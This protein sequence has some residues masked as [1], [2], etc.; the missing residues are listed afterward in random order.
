MKKLLT[1]I[2]ILAMVISLAACA[3]DDPT[4]PQ[5]HPS[6]PSQTVPSTDSTDPADPTL[7]IPAPSNPSTGT[8]LIWLVQQEI[9]VY[10]DSDLG[11][12][13][14]DYTYDELGNCLTVR[15]EMGNYTTQMT[16]KYDE[17]GFN[18]C[19]I[20]TQSGIVM[21]YDYTPDEL[22]RR[23]KAELYINDILDNTQTFTYDDN[24][25]LLVLEQVSGDTVSRN[26]YRYD[27]N[28]NVLDYTH[29]VDEIVS[30]TVTLAY[31]EL[32]RQISAT[33]TN[34]Q[35][36]VVSIASYVYDTLTETQITKAADGTILSR[37]IKTMDAYGN[38]IAME[39][40]GID[41]PTCSYTASYISIEVP[42][43]QS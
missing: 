39:T 2:L 31:D 12:V 32:G 21:R 10:T 6:A 7:T 8:K 37:I 22:G 26:V 18:T 23:A 13:I 30:S 24:G 41:I 1:S 19:L 34:D 40:V 42:A 9:Q 11:T 33:T 43:S 36:D 20:V 3:Q 35:G 28:G 5:D 16:L 4:Q 15:Q 38:V 29:Y 17:Q 14:T 27:K 25:N